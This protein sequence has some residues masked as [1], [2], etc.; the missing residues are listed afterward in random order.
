MRYSGAAF[1]SSPVWLR[2]F[3]AVARGAKNLA[4]VSRVSGRLCVGSLPL[5]NTYQIASRLL[6]PWSLLLR[7]SYC[8]VGISRVKICSEVG[9]SSDGAHIHVLRH[10][11]SIYYRGGFHLLLGKLL[12]SE[13]SDDTVLS[14]ATLQSENEFG[15][16]ITMSFT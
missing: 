1:A 16:L 11:G 9:V 14:I 13:V 15:G 7:S 10:V 6:G 3:R 8:T 5:P 4:R 12:L 2:G